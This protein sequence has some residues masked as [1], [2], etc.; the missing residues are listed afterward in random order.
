M[1]SKQQQ[2]KKDY[3]LEHMPH[4]IKN[5]PWFMKIND[6]DNKAALFHQRIGEDKKKK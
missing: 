3:D 5:A 1:S 2:S 6:D 4:F